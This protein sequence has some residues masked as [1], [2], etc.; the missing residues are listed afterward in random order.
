MTETATVTAAPPSA[1]PAPTAPA[2]TGTPVTP[3]TEAPGPK[4]GMTTKE[5]FDA[6]FVKKAQQQQGKPVQEPAGQTS[7]PGVPPVQ[8]AP[9]AATE[10]R[11]EAPAPIRET[12]PEQP[13]EETPE[14][15]ETAQDEGEDIP[16]P[17]QLVQAIN[18]DADPKLKRDMRRLMYIG[19]GYAN[20]GM[21]LGDVKK[22][23]AVA[24]TP[25]IL[26]EVSSTAQAHRE[27]MADYRNP[28]P[29]SKVRFVQRL[30]ATD[31]N[32]F[33]GLMS[34]VTEPQWIEKAM[35][36]RF[37][38]IAKAGTKNYIES[39]KREAART[40]NQDLL[41]AAEIAEEYGGFGN[42]EQASPQQGP[43]VDPE[44]AQRLQELEARDQAYR[45]QAHNG[46]MRNVYQTAANEVTGRIDGLVDQ[47]MPTNSYSQEARAEAKRLVGDA[48]VRGLSAN[49]HVVEKIN[50][51]AFN[52]QYD[53]RHFGTLV[54]F[55][56]QQATAALP[57]L[58]GPVIEHMLKVASPAKRERAERQAPSAP[59][60]R[61]VAS[62]GGKPVTAI[63]QEPIH[64]KGKD[65]KQVFDEWWNKK[66]AAR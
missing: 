19:L 34:T 48:I 7:A 10:P 5:G 64:V 51:L 56:I 46:F 38:A 21:R 57:V 61:D 30:A 59:P 60:R 29:E 28:S 33:T 42:R 14:A 4:R 40:N 17:R 2:T 9:V 22:Y 8:E 63:P 13:A 52:G 35:P 1:A 55:M 65:S 41:T 32:A 62:T 6:F 31:M 16:L 24:P 26:Q 43:P 45:S 49:P 53:E 20:S 3:S 66:A 58:A 12:A 50:Q 11:G 15:Q 39:M 18:P 23:I 54:G 44:T 37:V 36:E 25:E 47:A 27:L